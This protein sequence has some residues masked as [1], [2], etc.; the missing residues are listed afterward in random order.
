MM[1]MVNE[2]ARCL[3][4]NIV[5]S[6]ADADLAAILALGFPAFTGGPFHYL[7][8]MTCKTALK[9]LEKLTVLYGKRFEPAEIIREY[10]EK[11]KKFYE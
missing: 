5:E 3:Q 7:D 11:G 9:R 2:A 6:A 10:A 4:E 1:S 8:S